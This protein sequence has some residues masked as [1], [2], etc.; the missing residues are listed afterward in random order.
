MIVLYIVM[1]VVIATISFI[2]GMAYDTVKILR[3]LKKKGWRFEAPSIEDEI[4]RSDLI[5]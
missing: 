2:A 4:K 3:A 1:L 5:D